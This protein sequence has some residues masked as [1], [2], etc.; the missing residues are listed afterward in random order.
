MRNVTITQLKY[1]LAVEETR[2]FANAAKLCGI[3]QPTLSMM[4]KK[5]EEELGVILFDRSKSPTIV[6]TD[7]E[8]IIIRARKIFS[9]L[10]GLEEDLR[11]AKELCGEI[12][13]GLIP[14]LA[15]YLLP[16]FYDHF[17]KE[18]PQA[19]L[20]VFE[21][22]TDHLI[23]QLKR[24]KLD[25]GIL[26]TPLHDSE[27]VEQALFCERFF[28]FSN[29]PRMKPKLNWNDI[30][31][32]SLYLLSE[33][34]CFRH[35]TLQICK[36]KKV[37]NISFQGG[38][39]ETLLQLIK[40]N[41]GVTLIP[42]LLYHQLSEHDRRKYV[43][44]FTPPVPTREISL[45]AARFFLHEKKMSALA[46]SILANVPVALQSHRRNSTQIIPIA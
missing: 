35:Q 39:F 42:E 40:K 43:S 25:I 36:L 14:T 32:D 34:H 15:P 9:E 38:Q 45:V 37:D 8:K 5:L 30:P 3:S 17:H 19:H 28:I 2:N 7:G 1:V 44:E 18:H 13:L 46:E 29:S 20:K 21:L 26:A 10:S 31:T 11:F 22:Q 23:G 6:T 4:I 41:R 16:L 24:D 27:L 12:R 33:G